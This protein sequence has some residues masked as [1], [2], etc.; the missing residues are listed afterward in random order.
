MT[1]APSK[2]PEKSASQAWAVWDCPPCGGRFAS[3]NALRPCYSYTP[4]APCRPSWSGG[5]FAFRRSFCRSRMSSTHPFDE[6]PKNHRITA[7]LPSL[8]IAVRLPALAGRILAGGNSARNGGRQIERLLRLFDSQRTAA[9]DLHRCRTRP[10]CTRTL[11]RRYRR[12]DITIGPRG[13]QVIR[14][15]GRMRAASY[16]ALPR[17]AAI[18]GYSSA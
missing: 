8:G 14:F 4:Q 17:S 11:S 16:L 10:G 15:L 1:G 13:R 6:T 18:E 5:A 2:A 7:P 9:T 3:R 12:A